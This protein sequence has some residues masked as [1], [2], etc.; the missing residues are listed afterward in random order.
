MK[1]GKKISLAAER[2]F[3]FAFGPKI[4]HLWTHTVGPGTKNSFFLVDHSKTNI[5]G[6]KIIKIR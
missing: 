2:K 6:E 1:F 4:G 3:F 5:F